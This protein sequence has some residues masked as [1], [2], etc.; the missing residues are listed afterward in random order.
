MSALCRDG[1]ALRPLQRSAAC[2]SL[3]GF[4]MIPNYVS[5]ES[6]Q[7]YLCKDEA[8]LTKLRLVESRLH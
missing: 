8:L 3:S 6:D 7:G 5:S 4:D 1:G 2:S